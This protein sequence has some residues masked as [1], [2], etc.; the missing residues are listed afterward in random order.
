[1]RYAVYEDTVGV[2]PITIHEET[3]T[4]Y[5]DRKTGART[6]RWYLCEPLEDADALAERIVR[7]AGDKRG[8]CCL[9]GARIVQ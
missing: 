6:S 3:C 9:D 2:D 8:D 4:Y 7:N 5:T 1:M